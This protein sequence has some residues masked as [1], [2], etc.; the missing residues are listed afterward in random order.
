MVLDNSPF[1]PNLVTDAIRVVIAATL[2]LM[3]LVMVRLAWVR[4]RDI[5]AGTSDERTNPWLYLSY[6]AA[7]SMIATASITHLG[8]PPT[9]GG[10][11]AF[12]VVALGLMGLRKRVTIRHHYGRKGNA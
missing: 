9:W 12:V 5:R 1:G 4:W 6:A 2:C 7:L 8:E 3:A 11:F 10:Y